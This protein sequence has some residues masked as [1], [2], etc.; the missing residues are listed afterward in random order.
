MRFLSLNTLVSEYKYLG[1]ME[2]S[3][4][5]NHSQFNATTHCP[6]Q[7]FNATACLLGFFFN[8]LVHQIVWWLCGRSFPYFA[9]LPMAT[10]RHASNH[11]ARGILGVIS[12]PLNVSYAILIFAYGRTQFLDIFGVSMIALGCL[13][14]SNDLYEL[15]QRKSFQLDTLLHHLAEIIGLLYYFEWFYPTVE[16]GIVFLNLMSQRPTMLPFGALFLYPKDEWTTHRWLHLISW[17]SILAWP[18]GVLAAMSTLAAYLALYNS[19]IFL[20]N[21]ITLPLGL[22]MVLFLDIPLIQSM[23]S[24]VVVTSRK[25]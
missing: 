3:Q 8:Y 5:S 21:I 1:A 9:T 4:L 24:K 6:P 13:H 25:S 15:T 11:L 14:V 22:V 16:P 17:I 7:T 12:T 18:I 20:R 2:E 23:W 19:S 10:Q